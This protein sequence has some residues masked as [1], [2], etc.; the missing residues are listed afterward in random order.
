MKKL[1]IFFFFVCKCNFCFSQT[2]HIIDSSTQRPISYVAIKTD[3]NKGFY[4]DEN[5]QFLFAGNIKDS[6]RFSCMGYNDLS[7]A[8]RSMEDTIYLFPKA[9]K[10]PEIIIHSEAPK[11]KTLGRRRGNHTWHIYP[12]GQLGTLI[13]P[14]PRYENAYVQKIL[15]PI[16]KYT[17]SNKNRKPKKIKPD[18]NSVFKL[19]LFEN[20]NGIPGKALLPIPIDVYCNEDSENTVSVDI[21]E[22]QVKLLKEGVFICV[23]LIGEISTDGSIL[24]KE[25]SM[26]GFYFTTRETNDFVLES[27][28]KSASYDKWIKLDKNG[29]PLNKE[30]F[31]SFQL[32]VSLYEKE[33]GLH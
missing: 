28:Y 17:L 20:K 27:Y 10:L 8:S 13:K 29:P 32:V 7:I 15:I 11:Q 1:S 4:S 30:I 19:Q 18:F 21:S 22:Y 31:M 24:N 6:I 3:E 9:Q 16:S 14:N 12:K 23:Q 5:G 26:P 33:K 2:Y 25:I